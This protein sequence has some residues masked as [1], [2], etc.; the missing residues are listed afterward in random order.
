MLLVVYDCLLHL[1]LLNRRLVKDGIPLHLS[2]R[3]HGAH[4][5]ALGCHSHLDG[6]SSTRPRLG[7]RVSPPRPI[8]E[9]HVHVILHNPPIQ[10]IMTAPAHRHPVQDR[11]T[12][13][14]LPW[15]CRRRR[16]GA[17][18]REPQPRQAH[19]RNNRREDILGRRRRR[20]RRA[21]LCSGH[22]PWYRPQTLAKRRETKR[23]VLAD[24]HRRRV[25]RSCRMHHHS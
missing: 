21:R 18:H 14:R 1:A 11:C 2:H 7:G 5:P 25:D 22:E 3:L 15:G 9:V 10:S 6:F 20:R 4:T 24:Q 17:Q 12:A 16:A 8:R 23:T 19:R 13:R